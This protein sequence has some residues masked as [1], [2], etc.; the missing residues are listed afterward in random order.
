M[1]CSNCFISSSSQWRTINCKI[2]CNAC[3]IHYKRNGIHRNTTLVA[4]KL[5]MYLSVK[6]SI[7]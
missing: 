4:A 3:G 2:Y 6:Q 1:E 5:L 7:F